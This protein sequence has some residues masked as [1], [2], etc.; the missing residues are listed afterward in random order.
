MLDL[1]NS[2]LMKR[3]DLVKISLLIDFFTAPKA[4]V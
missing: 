2:I 1:V 3:L 4:Q